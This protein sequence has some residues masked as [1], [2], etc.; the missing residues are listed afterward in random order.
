M[1]LHRAIL[2]SIL[3]CLFFITNYGSAQNNDVKVANEYFNKRDYAKAYDYYKKLIKSNSQRK[4]I[5]NNY[6][7]S[8]RKLGEYDKGLNQIQKLIKQEPT[9]FAYRVDE[10]LLTEESGKSDKSA[11]QFEKL[12]KETKASKLDV[13]KVYNFLALRQMN[14]IAIELLL[15]SR[16]ALKS[17][18][19][20]AEELSILYKNLGKKDLMLEE[21]LNLLA[22]NG[23]NISN[24]QNSLQLTLQTQK[25]YDLVIDKIYARLSE[26]ENIDYNQLL[27]WIYMQQK[28]F[29][30]AFIQQ[31]SVDKLERQQGRELI[32]LGDIA[33]LNQDY[34]T[35]IKIYSYVTEKYPESYDFVRTK[36]K[37]IQTKETLAKQKYPVDTAVIKE[38]IDDY[39]AMISKS[40]NIRE[41]AKAKI[42]QAKLYAVYLKD[43]EKAITLLK[44]IIN[45]LRLGKTIQSQA[46]IF[47]ADIYVLQNETGEAML[48]YMQVE[49]TMADDELG[50]I[51]K[52]K[53]AKVSYFEGEF[54]LAQ[55]HLDILKRATQRKIANDAQDLSLLIKGNL[56]LDTTSIPME[57]YSKTELLIFQKRYNEALNLLAWINK[58]YPG[59]SLTDE[60]HFQRGKIYLETNE[61]QKAVQELQKVIDVSESVLTDD[62]LY[63]IAD[64]YEHRLKDKEKAKEYYKKLL[65]EQAGSIH[66]EEARKRYYELV[67]S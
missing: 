48:T 29:Y 26:R 58:E 27:V 65:L 63:M 47:L 16:K 40:R 5:Y 44:Q 22:G 37:L 53:T 61:Y 57:K 59:H 3:T 67:G 36:R 49:R 30:N 14:N 39:E 34:K 20:Y 33:S 62:A 51:S 24:V 64:I 56:D 32:E 13:D 12:K 1:V 54:E 38:I 11:Q 7:S 17:K 8:V 55:A 4:Y 50:N 15:E 31:K 18:Y 43:E 66:V 42:S 41:N 25:D 21:L 2:Y 19:E 10:I 6:V 23:R 46:K 45:N 9:S 28:D 60:I 52:L 35:A